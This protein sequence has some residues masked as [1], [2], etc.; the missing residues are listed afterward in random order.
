MSIYSYFKDH[1]LESKIG[2]FK[3]I[4]D[5]VK[6]GGNSNVLFFEHTVSNKQFAIKFLTE[7]SISKKV[8]RFIDEYFSLI[9]L[10]PHK[11][12]V[13]QYHLD[14]FLYQESESKDPI[15]IFY[16][17]MKRYSSTLKDNFEEKNISGIDLLIQL[18]NAMNHLHKFGVIHRDIKP[19]NIF[20]DDDLKEYVIGDFG[21][22]HF[23][24]EFVAKLSHTSPGDRLA[25]FS[26]SPEELMRSSGKV[27]EASDIY[28]LGQVIQW[29]HTGSASK[30]AGRPTFGDLSDIKTLALNRIIDISIQSDITKRFQSISDLYEEYQRLISPKKRYLRKML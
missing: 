9:Q 23:D 21:I 30:G 8:K 16:I 12:I 22:A 17:V 26:F 7:W 4:H 28:S 3:L 11:N 24:E 6:S 2:T 15:E 20:Y 18:C 29:F 13:K 1:D 19:E 5:G 27:S 10:P 14:S 25:N